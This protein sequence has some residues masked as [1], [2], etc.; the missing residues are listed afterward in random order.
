MKIVIDTN[1]L[2][3]GLLKPHG[4]P[5]RIV[6]ALL[7]GDL[8]LLYDARILDEY[9]EVLARPHL[10][11]T[12]DWVEDV[13]IYLEASGDYV[14]ASKVF[15]ALPDPDDAMFL[16]VA[17]S[18]NAPVLVTGNQRHFPPRLA[19]PVRVLTP[20]EFLVLLSERQAL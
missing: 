8:T 7:R 10:G 11:L 18:G 12:T 20:R 9:R 19:P 4:P 13:L 14:T 1:V 15:S 17:H 6:D 2:V 5:G 16:E 3:S